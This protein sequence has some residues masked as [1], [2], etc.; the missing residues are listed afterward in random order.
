MTD[1]IEGLPAHLRHGVYQTVA[2]QRLEGWDPTDRNVSALVALAAGDTAF[3]E[4]LATFRARHP[5]PVRHRRQSMFRRKTPYLIPGTTVLRNNFGADSAEM[6]ADLEC[7]ATAGRMVQWFREPAD[8]AAFDARDAHRHLFSDA[9]SWAGEYRTTELRRGD[10]GFAWQS[11]IAEDMAK[12]TDG[13]LDLAQAGVAYDN[14]R[15]S[16]EMAR[17][18]A[19]YNR[20]HPF[21]EGN[22]RTGA[23]LLH[24]IAARCGRRCDLTSV[25]RADW[26]AA[27]RDS[28]PLRRDG[29][30]SHRPFLFLLLRA[31]VAD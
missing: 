9:Y 8:R 12:L 13:V 7:V 10:Q 4:Y 1:M 6:L 3:A 15:L 23:L 25:R 19:D 26:Y 2:A 20:I 5:P 31:V 27:A 24:D 28:M 11:S 18:Y 17:V 16:Y 22:G 29:R 21:R 14:P 30:A